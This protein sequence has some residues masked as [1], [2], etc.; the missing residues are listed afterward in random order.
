MQALGDID[1]RLA[2]ILRFGTVAALD[3]ANALVTVS[4]DDLTTTEW[5]PWITARAGGDV[6]WWA[7]EPGEQVMVLSPSGELAHGVVLPAI[8]QSAHPA[9]GSSAS[10]RRVT[11]ADGTVVAY[12]RGAHQ[13]TVDVSA[14]SGTVIVNCHQATVNADSSVTLNTPTTHCTGNLNV[15]GVTTTGGLISTGVAGGAAQITGGITATGGSVTHN[16]KNIGST[17]THSGVQSG[18]SNTG[19]PT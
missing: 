14:S 1:R 6:S 16:G 17:H 3:A 2:N 12:D 15:D 18:L 13:L 19:A 8:Y 7:P 11:F 5:L 9:N 10:V 4:L